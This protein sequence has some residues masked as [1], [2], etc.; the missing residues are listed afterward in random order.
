MVPSTELPHVL[1][2]MVQKLFLLKKTKN[3]FVRVG[4]L[5]KNKYLLLLIYY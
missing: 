3:I 5:K 1:L 2:V 4:N